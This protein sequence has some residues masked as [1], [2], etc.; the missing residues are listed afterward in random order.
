MKT[1]HL[2]WRLIFSMIL[3]HLLL[4]FSF[5]DKTIFW[6]IFTG[7]VLVLIIYAMLQ[8]DVDDKAAFF[9]YIVIGAVSGGLLYFLFWLGHAGIELLNLPYQTEINR[10]YHR[11]APSEYWHYL[12][13]LLVAAPGEELFWRGFVQKRLLK[14]FGPLT[15]IS[16][17]AILYASVHIYSGAFLLVFSALI[18]GFVWGLL[19][20]WKRSMPLIIVSHIVFDLLIF[21]FLP[22][23]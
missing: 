17:A 18:S 5:H 4:Y 6:Y 14:Y 1:G 7:S 8:G 15:S 2:D 20:Q 9:Q 21:I 3:A 10:L 22:F 19:Y 13:L 11:Y 23:S 16:L 12:A